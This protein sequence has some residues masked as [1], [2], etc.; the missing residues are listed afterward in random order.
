MTV[1]IVIDCEGFSKMSRDQVKELTDMLNSV[2]GVPYRPFPAP[3]PPIQTA[4][5]P[6]EMISVLRDIRQWLRTL[7]PVLRRSSAI[8]GTI[9]GYMDESNAL[10]RQLEAAETFIHHLNDLR[11]GKHYR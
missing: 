6:S 8:L 3:Q 5:A 4:A 11:M 1:Q 2:A 9:D 10:D 7:E